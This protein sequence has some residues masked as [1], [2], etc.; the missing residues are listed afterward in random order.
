[1]SVLGLMALVQ[2]ALGGDAGPVDFRREVRPLLAERCFPCH[3]P[4][5]A[6]RKAKLRLDSATGATA[7]RKNGAAIVPG[8][9][10]RSELLARI[11][12]RDPEERMPPAESGKQPLDAREQELLRRWIAAG[13]RY[14]THWAWTAPRR[15]ELPAVRAESW[16]RDPL[17]RFVLARLEE[18][19]L[20]PAA[21]ADPERLLRR[22]TLDLSGLPPTLAELDAFLRERARDPEAA[23]AAAVERLLASP[24]H[25]E[26]LATQWL[27]LARYADTYGYQSDVERRVW[28]WRDWVIRAF[29]ANMPHDRFLVAQLAGDLLPEA[30]R[31]DVLATAFLRLHRQ[32]NEGGSTEE[33]FRSEYV[34]DRVNTF[35]TALLG[36]TLECAR[37]HDHKYDPFT[38][39][40]YYELASFFDDGDE[41]GLYSHFTGATPTPKLALPNEEQERELAAAEARVAELERDLAQHFE[42]L[43]AR[44]AETRAP[45]SVRAPLAR[46]SFDALTT[47]GRFANARDAERP[48]EIFD[49]PQLVP[50]FAGSALRFS[51]DNGARLP[52]VGAFQEWQP[53]SFALRL[54]LT[55]KKVRAVVLHRSY[56]WTDAASQG[57]Q[58]LVEDGRLTFALVHFWPGDAIAITTRAELPLGR[59]VH[60]AATYDGSMRA[61]GL[62]L[63]LDGERAECEVVRDKLTRTIAS[64]DPGWPTLAQRFRDNG[65]AGGAIDELALFDVELAGLEVRALAGLEPVGDRPERLRHESLATDERAAEL[66]A[67]LTEARRVLCAARAAVPEIMVQRDDGPPRTTFVLRRGR[68]DD[69]DRAQ[70]VE[71]GTPAVFPPLAAG[72]RADRLALARWLVAPEHP[73][74]ARVVVNRAWQLLFGRGLVETA[75]NFGVQGTLPANPEL[76][77]TLAVDLV[78]SGWD[79]RAL[80]RRIVLSA[81][82]RQDSRADAAAR[83]RDPA[84]ELLG[85]YPARRLAAE[86]I[87]DLALAASELLVRDVGGPSVR[88]WQPPGLWSFTAAGDYT[89]DEGAGRHRRSLYTFW[90]RTAPPPNLSLFDAARREVCVARRASTNTPQQALVLLNDPQFVECAGALARLVLDEPDDAARLTML[91]RRLAGRAPALDELAPLATLLV[92]ARTSYAGDLSAAE[93]LRAAAGC[94]LPAEA[95]PT[96]LDKHGEFPKRD[97]AHQNARR[98][99]DGSRRLCREPIDVGLPPKKCMRVEK[100]ATLRIRLQDPKLPPSRSRHHRRLRSACP[101]SA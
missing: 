12:A 38:T 44:S 20:A 45:L 25:A 16:P 100:N 23:Y 79:L 57:Y 88:P 8:E 89:P 47:E 66:R 54:E 87:R 34:A 72:E 95:D 71:P 21:P 42:R 5:E 1:M 26:H 14:E 55:E 82:Y 75:E 53:F 84:N 29:A 52:G 85:R 67:E 92:D 60:V 30:T 99:L 40:E 7:E 41:S 74:T 32:T 35:G 101:K 70:P 4:D 33:E 3:G 9:P 49:G 91:F 17:D 97:R 68:Y 36:V 51:G 24:A 90:K 11:T 27:D 13:A 31:D 63:W 81:T 59:F 48:G 94:E 2:A 18:A 65:L 56:A 28:P 19:Q 61:D 62:A 39:R 58:L 77:D 73:L 76:L 37:C 6:A 83:E 93:A 86:P 46:Y 50:G 78:A 22:V 43:R 10:E 15:S 64:G 80:L 69:P 96:F 98:R